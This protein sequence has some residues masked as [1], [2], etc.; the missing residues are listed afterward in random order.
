[1]RDPR[2]ALVS[3]VHHFD[4]YPDQIVKHRQKAAAGQTVS[5]RA[6]NVVP[7]YANSIHW[8]TGWLDLEGEI[9]I[10][11]STFED[12]VTDRTAFTEKYLDFYGANRAY[13]NWQN[14]FGTH[15]GVDEHFR[16]GRTDEW[17]EVFSEQD[18]E[19]LSS[20]LSPRLKARFGW[21]D[22][23]EPTK[24][25]RRRLLAVAWP[26]PR[27]RFLA[28]LFEG[29]ARADAAALDKVRRMRAAGDHNPPSELE[30]AAVRARLREV[31]DHGV[32]LTRL[33]QLVERRGETLPD[34]LAIHALRSRLAELSGP[35]EGSDPAQ[36][37]AERAAIAKELAVQ[38]AK[39]GPRAHAR[40]AAAGSVEMPGV[41]AT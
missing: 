15:V 18:A 37:E 34:G 16:S 38:E 25:D 30:E 40:Q 24:E 20:L 14:A 7:F 35:A 12:F 3:L 9:E 2:Q 10:L 6:M 29:D 17:R 13:F 31:P 5:E 1:V 4:M 28:W 26:A 32:L 22:P 39:E 23:G 19:Y 41:A 11:F 36:R 8:I 33:W 27:D 21:S